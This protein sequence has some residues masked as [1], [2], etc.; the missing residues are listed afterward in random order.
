MTVV[1]V[2]RRMRFRPRDLYAIVVDVAAYKDFLPLCDSSRVWNRSVSAEGVER[3][4][5]ELSITYD[6]LPI[7][8]RLTCEV[9]ADPH[10]LTIAASSTK[11]P[12]RRLENLWTLKTIPGGTDVI[13]RLDYLM[14]SRMLQLLLTGMFDY[15]MRKVMTAFEQRAA[16]LLSPVSGETSPAAEF[17]T[18]Q[19]PS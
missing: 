17:T 19:P 7:S 9:V 13:F 8:E 6:K 1:T 16:K 2:A 4:S 5:A 12:V 11:P 18:G 10:A 15:A 3:F 14:A